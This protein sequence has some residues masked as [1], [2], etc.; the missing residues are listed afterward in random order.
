MEP[1]II[2][3]LKAN[4]V[5]S[6]L[7]LFYLLVLKNDKS[8]WQ[9]RFYLLFSLLLSLFLPLLPGM[10]FS[11]LD[12]LQRKITMANPLNSL[13]ITFGN[14]QMVNTHVST[15]V[16]TAHVAIQQG[17]ILP[18][19]MQTLVGIYLLVSL[20]LLIR[21]A[22]KLLKLGIL[23]KKTD[24]HLTEGIYHCAF[25]GTAPFSFFKYM[26]INKQLFNDRELRQIIS[27]EK[28]HIQQWHSIDILFAEL[29]HTIL[30]VNP[31][32]VY[33]K[34]CIKLNH[35]YI[36]DSEVINS[37]VDKKDYQ[38]SILH[39]SFKLQAS[40]L[41][42]LYGSSKIKTRIKMMNLK[43]TPNA[44]LYKYAFV[45]LLVAASYFLINPSSASAALQKD[46][47]EKGATDVTDPLKA[48]EGL[49]KMPDKSAFIK[50]TEVNN[51]LVVKQLWN[52]VEFSLK[53]KSEL[54][55][56][57]TDGASFKFTKDKD[58]N[59]TQVLAFEHDTWLRA[60]NSDL[61][62]TAL[63]TQQLKAL[64]GIYQSEANKAAY[65]QVIAKQKSIIAKQ[66]WDGKEITMSAQSDVS[67]L[68]NVPYL[69]MVKFTKN[70]K[71]IAT[72]F[73]TLNKKEW[74]KVDS[75]H[76]ADQIKLPAQD[77]KKFEGYYE[78]RDRKGQFL[79]I[80]ATGNGLVL[81]EL[82]DN[83]LVDFTATG[84]LAF[85]T[86]ENPEFTLEFTADNTGRITQ[87]LAWG[88]DVWNRNDNY[89]ALVEIKL[90]SQ[91]LKKFVGKYE[92]RDEKGRFIQISATDSG[93]VLKQLWDNQQIGFSAASPLEFFSKEHT[94]FTLRFTSDNAG[95]ITQVLAFGQDVWNKVN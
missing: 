73:M 33:L 47:T 9:N 7:F 54:E 17:F 74:N 68:V 21:L 39:R 69:R 45:L 2:Y 92:F 16:N 48:I 67:F 49:Y 62:E 61:K 42:N 95:H 5:I 29:A 12:G 64:E 24:K 85:Y 28:V 71:G 34:R 31:L 4:V 46:V 43:K 22:I 79:Q 77:L 60:N 90:A 32:M 66:L 14:S 15:G 26:V 10:N 11:N 55:F 23:I 57:M 27:H 65:V 83:R 82:W 89:H 44:N 84:P 20:I 35:E 52:G 53:Q 81:K 91:D 56:T 70:D 63:N 75:Y 86:K 38:F 59:V 30:W 18:S 88:K 93:L 72:M 8:F 19:L 37:G 50:L 80:T 41:T 36:A 1:L 51:A 6:I 76:P 40:Q 3:L 94:N 87:V 58:G 78:F 25:D 13:Y